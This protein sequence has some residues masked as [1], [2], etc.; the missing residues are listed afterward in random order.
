MM[1]VKKVI[2]AL[3]QNK[4]IL[5]RSLKGIQAVNCGVVDTATF[6]GHLKQH[7]DGEETE[8]FSFR[9]CTFNEYLNHKTPFV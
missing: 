7:P 5:L 1:T 9:M 4:Y 3:E 2:K 6:K 8:Y